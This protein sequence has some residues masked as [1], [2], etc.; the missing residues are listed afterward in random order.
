M[1]TPNVVCELRVL[2]EVVQ[3]D[4]GNL[5]SLKLDD[6]PHTVAVDDSSRRSEMPLIRSSWINSAIFSM[7]FALLT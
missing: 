4:E 3:H 5:A 6:H 2:V 1:I 7:S